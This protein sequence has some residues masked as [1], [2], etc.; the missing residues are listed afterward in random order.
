VVL[1]FFFCFSRLSVHRAAEAAS[2]VGRP[3]TQACSEL[4]Q[5]QTATSALFSDD[6]EGRVL[7]DFRHLYPTAKSVELSTSE[8]GV[9]LHRP[10][11]RARIRGSLGISVDSVTVALRRCLRAGHESRPG[12]MKDGRPLMK[13]C[14]FVILAYRAAFPDARCITIR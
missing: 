1:F 2:E 6:Y 3:C 10:A 8:P 4:P 9:H 12:C 13:P 11:Y 7:R 14:T 5:R